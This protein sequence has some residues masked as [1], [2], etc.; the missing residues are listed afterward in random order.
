[1]EQSSGVAQVGQAVTQMDEA[2]Q[3]NAALVEESAAAAASLHSQAEQ[4]VKAVSGF[5]LSTHVNSKPRGVSKST[6]ENVAA[7]RLE[8][9][10]QPPAVKATSAPL[11][12]ATVTAQRSLD[13]K[14]A[15]TASIPQLQGVRPAKPA[16][17]VAS[18]SKTNK[19][20]EW[21]AF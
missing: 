9:G 21:E 5:R 19:G 7:H 17:S 13:A 18:A 14:A 2:T 6:P 10:A 4:I 15:S 20:Q 12:T 8:R 1:V 11:R 3:Q 16:N